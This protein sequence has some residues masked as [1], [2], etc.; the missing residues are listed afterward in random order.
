LGLLCNLVAASSCIVH[1]I[2]CK[3]SNQLP[4][5]NT[6]FINKCRQFIKLWATSGDIM[7][8]REQIIDKPVKCIVHLDSVCIQTAIWK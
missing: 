6:V 2:G 7:A 1:A 3:T 8:P 4:S 5:T